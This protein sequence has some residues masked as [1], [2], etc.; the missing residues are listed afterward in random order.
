MMN[1]SEIKQL[2]QKLESKK[3]DCIVFSKKYETR[4]MSELKQYYEGA[5]WAFEF[6]ISEINTNS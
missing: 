2:L 1:A 6:A 3:K 4:N 5:K